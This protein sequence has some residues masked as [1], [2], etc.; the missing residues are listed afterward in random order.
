MARETITP[1]IA[2]YG[3]GCR[4]I[5]SYLGPKTLVCVK[6]V[7]TRIVICI[8]GLPV[9]GRDTPTTIQVSVPSG[10]V[11]VNG[12][13][14]R[15]ENPIGSNDISYRISSGGEFPHPHIYPD[16]S[17]CMNGGKISNLVELFAMIT[18]TV[19]WN[20]VTE[21]SER[22][23]HFV[24]NSTVSSMGNNRHRCIT[25]FKTKMARTVKQREQTTNE[26]MIERYPGVAIQVLE[27]LR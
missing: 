4:L 5:E 27:A 9:Y 6:K 2:I 12:N 23:G 7:G 1:E 11:R 25:Q 16:G 26:Y 10:N 19:T 20:N 22:I 3:A 17:A 15:L 8:D 13:S 18:D 21:D 24:L 14:F